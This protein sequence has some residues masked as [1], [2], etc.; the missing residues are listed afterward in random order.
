MED[1]GRKEFTSSG[2]S[3]AMKESLPD[4]NTHPGLRSCASLDYRLR[5]CSFKTKEKREGQERR[6]KWGRLRNDLRLFANKM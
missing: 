1:R 2:S 5:R 4:K 3:L 6:K